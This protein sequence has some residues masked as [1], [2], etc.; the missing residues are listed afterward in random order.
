MAKYWLQECKK[1]GSMDG[2]LILTLLLWGII[3]YNSLEILFF[4]RARV[5]FFSVLALIVY[6]TK[7]TDLRDH[8]QNFLNPVVFFKEGVAKSFFVDRTF[9]ELR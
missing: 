2:Y 1:G 8:R 6:I 7:V 4:L 3:I 9:C 5:D